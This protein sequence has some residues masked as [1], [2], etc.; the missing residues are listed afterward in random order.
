MYKSFVFF[1]FTAVLFLSQGCGDK[2]QVANAP[3]HLAAPA[4]SPPTTIGMDDAASGNNA[5]PSR[6]KQEDGFEEQSSSQGS[7]QGGMQGYNP[8]QSQGGPPGSGGPSGYNPYSQQ[9]SQG[10]AE[11]GASMGS[12]QSYGMGMGESGR[13]TQEFGNPNQG[14][15]GRNPNRANRPPKPNTFKDQAVAAFQIGNSKSAYTL[16]QAHAL[17]VS[18]E[19]AN[20]ILKDYRWAAHHKRPQLGINVAVGVTLMNP[21]NSTDL[22]PIGSASQNMN[23]GGGSDYGMSPSGMGMG[24]T[25]SNT[26]KARTLTETT[27]DFGKNVVASFKEKHSTGAWAPALK[28]Y[29]LATGRGNGPQRGGF[30][31]SGFGDDGFG[32]G[33]GGRNSGD[34]DGGQPSSPD[35]GGYPAG[36]GQQMGPQMGQPMGQPMGPQMGQ[37]G[38]AGNIPNYGQQSGFANA[39]TE[40]QLGNANPPPGPKSKGGMSS[41]ALKFVQGRGGF[42]RGSDENTS[43]G[44]SYSKD[45]LPILQ[46]NC[47]SCHQG[48]KRMGGYSLGDFDAML[49]GGESGSRAIVP[50][51]SSESQLI[52]EI[53]PVNGRADMPKKA[54]PLSNSEIDIIK[55]WIDAGAINDSQSAGPG[56]ATGP[57]GGREGSPTSSGVSP[58]FVANVTL[59]TGTSPLAPCLNY[60]GVDETSKLIKKAAQEG[61]DGLMIFEVKIGVNRVLRKVT[62]ETFVRIIQPNLVPKDAK[63]FHSSKTFSNLMVARSRSKSEPDGLEEEIDRIV[64]HLEEAFPLQSIPAALTPEIISNKRLPNL[65]KDT[66]TS[67]IDRLSEVNLY[68]NKGLLDESQKAD[69]FEQI[70]GASGKAIAMG[71]PTERLTA[72]EKLLEREFK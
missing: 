38:G 26:S 44:P 6:S 34:L 19:E 62:N 51:R 43:T 67:V 68:Y 52:R 12:S 32:G 70:A 69:A 25:S 71:S 14:S 13:N 60:I 49:R 50:G 35:A 53:V 42:G 10:S 11:Y 59:P 30:G 66:E 17:N 47:F 72:I 22:S 24:S 56:N 8:T 45:V 5:G 40:D 64:K 7:A 2:K 54:R 58:T 28:E 18:D 15:G 57:R 63:R 48:S 29:S 31:N 39:Q 55:R 21:M 61:Y 36:Y 20:E 4:A 16:L 27:G 9:G 41:G 46:A 1:G 23:G 65:I 37:Q 33:L 3:P